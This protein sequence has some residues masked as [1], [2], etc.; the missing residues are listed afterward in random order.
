MDFDQSRSAYLVNIDTYFYI[1]SSKSPKLGKRRDKTWTWTFTFSPKHITELNDLH[2]E[3][4]AVYVALVC[5]QRSI[6]QDK[7]DTKNGEDIEDKPIEICLLNWE[8]VNQCMDMHAA[9]QQ[10]INV[11]YQKNCSFRVWGSK[12]GSE[13]PIVVKQDTLEKL[14]I[15]G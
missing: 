14:E 6:G 13:D 5:G 8:Q 3:K 12:N 7:N 11:K 2:K 9:K 1:K 4:V 10:N 15:P